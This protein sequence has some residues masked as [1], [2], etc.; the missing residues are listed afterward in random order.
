MTKA[1]IITELAEQRVVENIV[2]VVCKSSRHDLP[3]LAQMI[4]VALLE[5]DD[6][7]IRSLH[8][9]G[10]M[11]YFIVRIVRNQYFSDQSPYYRIH[12]RLLDHSVSAD[13]L[14]NTT[15]DND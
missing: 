3:D 12:R 9:N 10:Q 2:Q 8:D 7:K 14:Q 5:Y 15:D 6:E 13:F 4:Y 1:E 11:N